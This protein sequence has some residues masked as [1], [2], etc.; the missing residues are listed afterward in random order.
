MKKP[1]KLRA[2]LDLGRTVSACRN[3]NANSLAFGHHADRLADRQHPSALCP[4]L[5]DEKAV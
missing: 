4:C 5:G 1:E 2:C 3:Q